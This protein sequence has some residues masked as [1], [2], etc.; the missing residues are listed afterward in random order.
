MCIGVNS[1]IR[2]WSF[3]KADDE[4]DYK[5]LPMGQEHRKL[6]TVSTRNPD[7]GERVGFRPNAVLSG[8]VGACVR[9]DRPTRVH[10]VLFNRI[11]GPPFIGYFGDFG[12]LVLSGLSP[13]A[14]R[15]SG[16]FCEILG[17]QPKVAK[18]E[19]AKSLVFLGLG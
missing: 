19:C 14:L 3:F 16:R 10:S 6:A 8:A 1:D 4:S 17:T 18:T 5:R 11:F 12:A 7:K 2:E 13:I 15:T 9:Y